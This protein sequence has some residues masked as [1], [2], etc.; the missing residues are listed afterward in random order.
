MDFADT[1]TLAEFANNPATQTFLAQSPPA[2]TVSSPSGAATSV[3]PLS[4]SSAASASPS[5]SAVRPERPRQGSSTGPEV[6]SYQSRIGV[7]ASSMP[8]YHQAWMQGQP[9]QSEWDE[10]TEQSKDEQATTA[11]RLKPHSRSAD[12]SKPEGMTPLQT[13]QAQKPRP[14][15]WQFG[16]RSRN[17]PSEAMFAL[18][19]AIKALGAEWELGDIRDP[20]QQGDDDVSTGPGPE[21]SGISSSDADSDSEQTVRQRRRSSGASRRSSA[22]SGTSRGRRR[23]RVRYGS[24]NDWGYPVPADPWVIEARFRKD[25]MFPLGVLHAGSTNNSRLDLTAEQASIA[26]AAGSEVGLNR[27]R[28][29]TMSSTTSVPQAGSHDNPAASGPGISALSLGSVD[30]KSIAG[31]ALSERNP[32]ADD[33]AYVYVTIQLYSIEKEFYLVDFKCAGYERLV[34]RLVRQVEPTE[35][36]GDEDEDDDEAIWNEDHRSDSDDDSDHFQMDI[37]RGGKPRE[38]GHWETLRK[39]SSTS[40][41][42]PQKSVERAR[43]G[44]DDDDDDDEEEGTK[45]GLKLVEELVGDGRVDEKEKASPFPFL[46]VASR[47]II[48]LAEAD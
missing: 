27:H 20:A 14:T 33:S 47:L 38:G 29:S 24:W 43:R 4:I 45:S 32:V 11:A 39:M 5:S 17:S 35:R 16:I 40:N 42:K 9:K 7:L 6:R 46:D 26:S 23:S 10:A 1:H 21:E 31:S 15:K 3:Q 13:Q 44:Y 34:R 25:G 8:E 41:R 19:K 12:K 36:G 30:A 48:Q 18:L 37:P 2:F 28:S 22:H